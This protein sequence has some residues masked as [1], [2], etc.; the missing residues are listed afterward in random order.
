M[1]SVLI[2]QP[3]CQNYG[4]MISSMTAFTI[5]CD[6]IDQILHNQFEHIAINIQSQTWLVINTN[7]HDFHDY[8]NVKMTNMNDCKHNIW[9]QLMWDGY[10]LPLKTFGFSLVFTNHNKTQ[11]F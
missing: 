5:I 1:Y 2:K 6:R 11:C 4:F 8:G 3:L 10:L 9:F 7:T